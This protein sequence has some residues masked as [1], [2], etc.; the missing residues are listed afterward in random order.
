[1]NDLLSRLHSFS[2]SYSIN[3]SGKENLQPALDRLVQ[4]QSFKVILSE[5]IDQ[6][7]FSKDFGQQFATL[8]AVEGIAPSRLL[9]G[10]LN[11]ALG[12]FLTLFA[13]LLESLNGESRRSDSARHVAGD[14]ALD[15]GQWRALADGVLE[16][17]D[18]KD[19]KLITYLTSSVSDAATAS[20]YSGLR[21]RLVIDNPH[22]I[23]PTS[24]YRESDGSV[25]STSDNLTSEAV[26]SVSTFATIRTVDDSLNC[27][28][29]VLRDI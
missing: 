22:A 10:S 15:I 5:L 13:Q 16:D 12:H 9:R 1:M 26:M 18:I 20:Y 21:E 27:D 7:V 14:G 19:I 25:V 3:Y 29:N 11:L 2:Q 17:D 6:P 4:N 28:N 23:Y 24:G 8:G